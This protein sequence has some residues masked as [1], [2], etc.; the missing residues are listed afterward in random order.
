MKEVAPSIQKSISDC[1]EKVN[2]MS[3]NLPSMTKHSGGSTSP[4]QAH[5]SGKMMVLP[6]LYP[7]CAYYDINSHG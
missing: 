4:I 1:T 5:R 3:S 7:V 6:W 2:S